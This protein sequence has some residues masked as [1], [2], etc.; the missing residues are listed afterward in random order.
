MIDTKET[1]EKIV[2]NEE[3]VENTIRMESSQKRYFRNIK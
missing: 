3:L 2:R 1:R